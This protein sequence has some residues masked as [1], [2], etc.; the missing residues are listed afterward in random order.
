MKPGVTVVI[1]TIPT[2]H[3][4]ETLKRALASVKAQEHAAI[5]EIIVTTD[6]THAGAAA[7]RNRGLAKVKTE[8]TAFLD[9]D[10]EWLPHHIHMLTSSAQDVKA[11]VVYPWFRVVS[12][13]GFDPF[14]G[15]FNRPFSPEI[16]REHNYIPVTVLAR[17]EVVLN[18]GGFEPYGEQQESACDDWGLWLKLLNSGVSFYHVPQVTW[19]WHWHSQHTSGL[20]SRW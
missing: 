11:D 3:R 18:A 12:S 17:T 9:D 4:R 1:P 6:T 14:P 10:D 16:L 5:S 20:G 7:T 8:W 15:A 19:L 13:Q 2:E